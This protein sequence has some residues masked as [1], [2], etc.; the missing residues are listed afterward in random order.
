DVLGG[1][2]TA[3]A[4]QK[5]GIIQPYNVVV[6]HRQAAEVMDVVEQTCK[7]ARAKLIMVDH[8]RH[9]TP[10][11][12]PQFQFRNWQLAFEVFQYV[13]KR[14]VLAKLGEPALHHT[15]RTIIPAR[16]EVI[17]VKGKILI[18]DGSHN[19]QKMSALVTSV[20]RRFPE[21][22]VTVLVS[23]VQSTHSRSQGALKQLVKLSPDII[24]TTFSG[25]QDTPKRSMDAHATAKLAHQ[26]GIKRVEVIENPEQ[27]FRELMDSKTGLLLVTGSFYLL[28]HVRPLIP[29]LRST[30][31]SI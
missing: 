1:T 4:A 29:K 15:M 26:A 18:I 16:M 13:Q 8:N 23:F 22:D 24:V 6:M 7:K 11:S 30:P 10:V 21:Q 9:L 25:E 12:M 19:G 17:N 31:K 27:A 14:D 28:N 5:S 3:I 20:Q 2:L